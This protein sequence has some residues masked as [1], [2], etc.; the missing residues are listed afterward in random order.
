[1]QIIRTGA[2]LLLAALLAGGA[3]R[4]DEVAL[5]VDWGG[6]SRSR[7]FPVTGGV[8]FARGRLR[9]ARAVQLECGGQTLP[10]Q[11]QALA[12]WPDKSVKWLLLDFQA[13]TAQTQ[14]T[15]HYGEGVAGLGASTRIIAAERGGEV[16]VDTGV[17][18]FV[19]RR[20]GMR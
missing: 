18:R 14:L 5:T 19:V 3:A 20:D 9:D 17:L 13:T 6:V 1:M 11:T 2:G 4:A 16:A 7:P 15:L 12:W 10:L 8:P